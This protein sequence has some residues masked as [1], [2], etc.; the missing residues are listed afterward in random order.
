MANNECLPILF[1]LMLIAFPFANSH[2]L[3]GVCTR[4]H[5]AIVAICSV[6]NHCLFIY[7]LIL[8]NN[9]ITAQELLFMLI[10]FTV[11]RLEDHNNAHAILLFMVVLF[12]NE[13]LR[14]NTI[15]LCDRPAVDNTT[16]GIK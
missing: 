7:C 4:T 10:P 5:P 12:Y 11:M 14:I 8:Y 16:S 9:I 2:T 1:Y 3:Q 13:T 6:L 15:Y